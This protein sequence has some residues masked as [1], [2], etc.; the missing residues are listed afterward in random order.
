LGETPADAEAIILP[1]APTPQISGSL[2]NHI[3]KKSLFTEFLG[4]SGFSSLLQTLEVPK[5]KRDIFLGV[6]SH[7]WK[8]E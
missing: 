1:P 7:S 6:A 4:T 5:H 2:Q 3:E 8:E